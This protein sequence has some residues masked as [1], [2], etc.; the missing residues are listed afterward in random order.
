MQMKNN[1][2]HKMVS[3]KIADLHLPL[4][5]LIVITCTYGIVILYSAEGASMHPLVYKQLLN[6]CVCMP[7]VVV[8]VF[9]DIRT[10]YKSAWI[11]YVVILLMLISVEMLGY[12]AKGGTRWIDLGIAKIQPS[13]PAKLVVVIMLARYFHSIAEQKVDKLRYLI[14]PIAATMLPAMLIIKQPDLGTGGIILIIASFVFFA[15]GVSIK[16]FLILFVGLCLSMPVLWAFLREY[17]K[18]RILVFLNPELDP[19]GAGYNILQSKI[20]IGSGGIFG[21]GLGS[22]TQSQLEFL[23]EHQTDFIF[24]SLSEDFGFIGGMILLALYSMI[25]YVSIGIAINAKSVFGKLLAIGVVSMFFSHIFINIGMVMGLVPVVG[26][27]LPLIS[28][29]GT[30]IGSMLGG[31]ALL[32]NVHVNQSVVIGKKFT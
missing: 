7:L 28:Y 25:I 4:I 21:K 26:V 22:G 17:Q 15:A 19:L 29:G 27:P 1:I 20:S 8:I 2:I 13:E 18:K 9:L 32:M 10:I 23:P 24:A 3:K 14:F 12:T 16:K 6:I 30:M 11:M 5:T 31:F